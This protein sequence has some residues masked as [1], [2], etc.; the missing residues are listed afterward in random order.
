MAQ[1]TIVRES[2][3]WEFAYSFRVLYY[4]HDSGE[5]DSMKEKHWIGSY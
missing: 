5:Q 1:A 3:K 4:C 2:I